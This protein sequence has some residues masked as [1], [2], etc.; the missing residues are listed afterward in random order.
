MKGMRP[1]S[2]SAVA[3]LLLA[4]IGRAE[5]DPTGQAETSDRLL[6]LPDMLVNSARLEDYPLI[7]KSELK[8]GGL[9]PSEPPVYLMFPG[10][11]YADGVPKGQATV[12]IEL[13]EQGHATDY[14][15]VAYTE[16]YFGEALL[17]EAKI[18]QYSP[19]MFRGVAVPT[20]FDLGYKFK[21]EFTVPLNGFDAVQRR[22]LLIRGDRPEFKYYPVTETVLDSRLERVREAVPHWPAGYTPAAGREEWVMVTCYIDETG[23]VRVPRVE[24]SPSP[25]LVANALQAVR[26]WR[27]KPPT[28]KGKPV[29]VYAAFAVGFVAAPTR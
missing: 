7:P 24:S 10:R 8:G 21:P 2:W 5:T 27:F 29:L 26:F 17:E 14:L 20:R 13:D 19:L 11:A 1:F 6:V 9:A 4:P 16:Q 25:L 18:T 23:R 22:Q 12:C 15:L 28:V 3:L